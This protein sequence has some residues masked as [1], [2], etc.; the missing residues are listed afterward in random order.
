MTRLD[1]KMLPKVLSVI[2]DFGKDIVYHAVPFKKYDPATSTGSGCE[3][4]FTRKSSPP[5]PF[6]QKFIDGDTIQEGDLKTIVAG[7]GLP[8]V[9]EEGIRAT[10]DGNNWR[11]VGVEPFYSGDLIAAFQLHLRLA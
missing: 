1:D 5:E 7:S 10:F 4:D 8:F 3:E 6:E 9:V 11:V 2:N